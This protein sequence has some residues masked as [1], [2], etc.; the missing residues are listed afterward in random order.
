M[1]ALLAL[2]PW[3]IS[4]EIHA[5]YALGIRMPGSLPPVY[6]VT[7]NNNIKLALNQPFE[8]SESFPY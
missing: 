3:L 4:C 1:A 7:D 6:P 5:G 2:F 8:K